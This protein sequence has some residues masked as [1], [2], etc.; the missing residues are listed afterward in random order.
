[1]GLNFPTSPSVGTL[2]PQ[3]AIAGVPVY[4]WDG[5]KWSLQS[6][7]SKQPIY[8][9]GSIPMSAQLKLIAPPVAANDAA[10]KSYVDGIAPPAGSVRYDSAQ[11]SLTA[12]QQQQG[13]QNIYAAPF[14]ALGYYGMQVNGGC[15]IDQVSN[16]AATVITTGH[17]IADQWVIGR[18]GT[19]TLNGQQVVDG[20]PGF[21]YSI[22]ATITAG[23]ASPAPSD[24]VYL[25]QTIEGLRVARCQ[26]G[27]ATAQPI[28]FAFWAKSHRPGTYGGALQNAAQNRSYPFSFAVNVADTWEYKTITIPGDT[29]GTW[30]TGNAASMTL[31]FVMANGA[32]LQAPANAWFAGNVIGPTGTINGAQ[33][34]TD[35]FQ[36]TGLIMLPGLE[37]PSQARSPFVQRT[38][39]A[40]LVTCMR[41]L[42]ATQAPGAIAEGYFY[43]AQVFFWLYHHRVP[44][45]TTP[46]LIVKG[47]TSD[48]GVYRVGANNPINTAPS[49]DNPGPLVSHG[50]FTDTTAPYTAGQGGFAWAF[51]GNG[52]MLFD[53][54]V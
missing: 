39:D 51:N 40:E 33:A 46:G 3:P 45:R 28:S 53:A 52:V 25:R 1:M 31:W 37:L 10:A 50:R 23:N 44:K 22:K 18:N 42:E 35:T 13:R 26:F 6:L 32:T 8:D 9:D 21:T 24:Y 48:F 36:I 47:A 16:G 5:E 34:A 29:T 14:D 4:R 27:T 30:I 2:C 41:Y 49:L 12:T 15:A 7:V 38:Y 20:P 19:W 54:R 11:S 17:Y 43:N